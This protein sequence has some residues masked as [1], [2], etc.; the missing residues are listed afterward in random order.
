MKVYALVGATGTGKSYRAPQIAQELG[1]DCIIDDGLLISQGKIIA[2]TSAKAEISKIRAAKVAVFYFPEHREQVKQAIRE[3]RP[4]KILILG[5]SYQMV[6]KICER[7]ELP[8][9]EEVINIENIVSVEEIEL[10][11]SARELEG[12]HTIP[13]PLVEIKRNLWGNLVDSLPLAVW[14]F[15]YS[16]RGKTVVRPPFSYL[17][18][19]VVSKRALRSLIF[20]LLAGMTFIET[21]NRIDIHWEAGGV[22]VVVGCVFRKER[23]ISSACDTLRKSLQ[24]RV[25]Y[26]TGVELRRIDVDIEG[27]V[28]VKADFVTREVSVVSK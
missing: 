9:P 14:R 27:I 2:G 25:M 7:L 24:D 1:I 3:L 26:L 22:V 28:G 23:S 4:E 16:Y 5:I 6:C 21:V 17:G 10:A 11:R 8:F 15:F 18:K 19:L 20:K 13:V 12:K